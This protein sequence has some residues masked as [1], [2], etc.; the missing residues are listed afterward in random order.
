VDQFGAL[1]LLPPL[2]A[3]LLA[4][5]F[6]HVYLALGF[7]IFLGST[8]YSDL[9]PLRGLAQSLQYLVEVFQSESNTKVIL[10]SAL[11]GALLA[12]LQKAGGIQALIDW[13]QKKGTAR[14]ERQTSLAA[15][16][17]G[18]SIFIESNITS[19]VVG[20]VFRPLFDR[21]KIS[22]EKLAYLCDSTSAP[23]CILIPLNGWGALIMGLLGAQQ[24]ERP[25]Q[26]L[27]FSLP[28]AFYPIAAL[29]IL[30]FVISTGFHIGPLAIAESR[31]KKTGLLHREGA[32]PLISDEITEMKPKE[33][34][35]LRKRNFLMPLIIMICS[36]PIGLWIT[37]EG[38]F[39][40]GSGSTS[41]LWAVSLA[42][43]FLIVS[44]LYQRHFGFHEVTDLFFQGVGGLMP[45]VTLL[46][47]AFAL[48]N[49]CADLGVGPYVAGFAQTWILPAFIPGLVFILASLIAFSTG[50]S[51]GTFSIMFPIGVPLALGIGMPV[52]LIAGAILSGGIF[53][54][55]CSPISDTTMIASMASASDHIDHVRTQLPY[56]LMGGGL[57]FLL[58]ISFGFIYIT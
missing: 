56:A 32:E 40:K 1:S 34:I 7:G 51:W 22:R 58:Y 52:E 12:F 11:V 6:R 55:H 10:F 18:C 5:L 21:M 36:V 30:L 38:E 39:M 37:G 45:L 15:Y 9:N 49:V 53:G 43:L 42:V 2:S 54:D 46:I 29:F 33:E 16:L 14:S 23:I 31:V 47:L 57:A 13:L 3:I 27:L 24:M 19:L 48:G 20:S 35:A 8:L 41:V 50:T 28:F 25:F 26:T 44:G 4:L 17:L